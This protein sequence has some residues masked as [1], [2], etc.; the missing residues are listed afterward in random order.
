VIASLLVAAGLDVTTETPAAASIFVLELVG[1]WVCPCATLCS[2]T[3]ALKRLSRR[4]VDDLIHDQGALPQYGG[5]RQTVASVTL[6]NENGKPTKIRSTSTS[7]VPTIAET[8]AVQ[9]VFSKELLSATAPCAVKGKNYSDARRCSLFGIGLGMSLED[10]KQK[11][12]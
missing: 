6:Q 9:L 1:K 3:M 10:V 5:T 4:M 12:N 11:A 7:H 2:P 8:E